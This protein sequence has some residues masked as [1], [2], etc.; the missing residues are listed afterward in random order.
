MP[1]RVEIPAA[2][3]SVL[4]KLDETTR[5]RILRAIAGLETNPRP[6]G[7]KKLEGEDG[8]YRIR[9]GDYRILYEIQDRRLCVLVVKVGHRREVYKG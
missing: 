9:V 7:V 2:V 4:R 1:Y 6:P 8:A 5:E 3:R